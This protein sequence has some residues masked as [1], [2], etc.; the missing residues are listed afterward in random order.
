MWGVGAGAARGCQANATT[1]PTASSSYTQI[2]SRRKATPC[3]QCNANAPQHIPKQNV[4]KRKQESLRTDVALF[5]IMQSCVEVSNIS[6][7]VF[8]AVFGSVH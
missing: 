1:S 6:G 7:R 8:K 5:Q 3:A 2:A 4:R